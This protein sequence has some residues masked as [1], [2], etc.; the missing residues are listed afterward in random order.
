MESKNILSDSRINHLPVDA[1]LDQEL[2]QKEDEQESNETVLLKFDS[3]REERQLAFYLCYAIDRFDYSVPLEDMIQNFNDGFDVSLPENLFAIKLAKGAIENHQQ[4]DEEITPFLKNWRLD[5][6]GC[7]T[8]LILRLALWELQQK[9]CIPSIVINEAVELAKMFAEKDAYK[10]VNGILDE[11][12]K[13]II[14]Q[15]P[16]EEQN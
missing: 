16:S 1:E 14:E 11:I 8:R 12:C 9:D 5:R 7:C 3:R 13:N 15:V 4:L 6:L 2:L 10:F